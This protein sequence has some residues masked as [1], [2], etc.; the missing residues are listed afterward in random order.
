MKKK[1]TSILLSILSALFLFSVNA[2]LQAEGTWKV[3]PTYITPAQ[4]VVETTDIVYYLTG[5]NLF[6]YDKKND[7]S[8][9]YTTENKLNDNN[10]TD[11]YY[12]NEKKYLTVCYENGN[13]DLLYDD[14]RVKNMSDIK[15]SNVIPPLTITNVYFDGDYIYVGTVFGIVKFNE[16]RAEVVTSGNYGKRINCMGILKDRLIIHCEEYFYW[17]DKNAALNDINKFNK[18]YKHDV[19][20]EIVPVSENQMLLAMKHQQ[21]VFVFNSIDFEKGTMA[22]WRPITVYHKVV[23]KYIIHGNGGIIYYVADN[24]LYKV[25]DDF[26][27]EKILEFPEEYDA[28]CSSTLS[29]K[30]SMWILNNKGLGNFSFD[31]EGGVTVNA[32]YMRPDAFTVS[33][34]RYFFPSV[35]GRRLYA[36]NSGVTAYRFG[37]S[38]RGLENAQTGACIDL[39]TQ[40]FTDKTPY[41]VEAKVSIVSNAQRSLGKYAIAPTAI[42]EDPNDPSVYFI[43]TS[44]DGIYKIKNGQYV[45]RYDGD[46]SP[47]SLFD[48]RYIVYGISM[49]KAGNLWAM[50][51]HHNWTV[52]PIIILPADKVK[53]DPS[54]VKASDW[55][56]PDLKSFDC[57]GEMDVKMLHCRKSDKVFMI[58]NGGDKLLCWDTKGTFNNFNDDDIYLW[59]SWTD[60][61]GNNVKPNFRSAIC[62][63]NDGR[64]WI[65]TTEGIY[66]ISS[67]ANAFNPNMRVTHLKV[68]R[69]DGSNLADYLLGTDLVM[70][71]AVDASN[72]KWV[73]TYGSGLFLVSETG[74]EILAN[75][76]TDNSPL[77]SNKVNCVYVDQPTGIVYIGTDSGLMSYVSDA[78]PAGSDYS[79]VFVYPNPVRPEFRGEV[80]ITG[81]MENSLVKIADVSGAVVYQGRSEGGCFTWN[82]CN[83]A[84]VRVKSGVYYVMMS[85]NATGS[86]TAAVAKIMVIN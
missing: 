25:T 27:E 61:D 68:P 59:E 63:D 64:I 78:T 7:E 30:E 1:L 86:S 22:L 4:K 43:S 13:I 40:E 19:P 17:I 16:P 12:N 51:F 32:D 9:Y 48:S 42:A 47:N 2:Q 50:I 56:H 65:G 55:V 34:V 53:L 31:D 81:L 33:K 79:E 67:A 76:T 38:T 80:N 71:I 60:Q 41:P 23:P 45:G 8:C 54:E 37:G 26:K 20:F 18:L 70:D 58:Y 77:L 36:Q 21:R 73:A 82:V 39:I 75:Y 5:G 14:G 74:N 52:S 49:D 35:D 6:S 11:I 72:R 44:D 3:F 69:N 57:W 24:T 10:I 62:E 84:G 15:D 28:S 29:G 83:T 66:E 85:Q 46:N